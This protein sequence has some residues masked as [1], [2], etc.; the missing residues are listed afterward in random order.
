MKHRLAAGTVVTLLLASVLITSFKVALFE[1]ALKQSVPG[2]KGIVVSSNITAPVF[3][4][5]MSYASW[6]PNFDSADSNESLR[7]LRLTNTDWVAICVFWYQDNI[8]SAEIYPSYNTPSNSSVSQAVDRCHELGMKVML[9]PMVDPM[10]GNWRSQI[11]PSAVWFR[12]YANFINFWA[13]FSQEYGVDLLCVGCE[14]TANDID[15][16]NWDSIVAGVRARYS[17]PIT[18]AA[19][20]FGL[21]LGLQPLSKDTLVGFVGL[22]GYRRLLPSDE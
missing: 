3:Q 12:N 20:W 15:T 16:A 5:G 22:C 10:D 7:L 8:T 9:K 19:Y 13:D 6:P 21:F 11:P 14:F 2:N 17:G 18:Y 4:N 1:G